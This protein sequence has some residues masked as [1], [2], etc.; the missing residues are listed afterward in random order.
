MVSREFATALAD[1]AQVQGKPLYYVANDVVKVY[2]KARQRGYDLEEVI[3]SYEAM[4]TLRKMG[5]TL[6][7]EAF[8]ESITSDITPE[9]ALIYESICEK[10]GRSFGMFARS[11]FGTPKEAMNKF[12]RLFS[13]IHFHFSTEGEKDIL[14]IACPGKSTIRA[15]LIA[16]MMKGFLDGFDFISHQTVVIEGLVKIEYSKRSLFH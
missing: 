13:D 2:L 7:S 12:S 3:E 11:S 1:D 14:Y 16:R 6:I 4:D 5:F 15:S 10:T 8:L 9:N